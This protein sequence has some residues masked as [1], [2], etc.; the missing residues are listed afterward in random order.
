MAPRAN[1]ESY[2]TSEEGSLLNLLQA[3]AT[4]WSF[5][6]CKFL[7]GDIGSLWYELG[8]E[9]VDKKTLDACLLL[10]FDSAEVVMAQD[11]EWICCFTRG[12]KIPQAHFFDSQFNKWLHKATFWHHVFYF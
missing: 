5:S 10:R 6:W 12:Q 1:G 8:V 3:L 4:M 2:G 9:D 7:E 11:V